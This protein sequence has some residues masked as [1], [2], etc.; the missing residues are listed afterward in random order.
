MQGLHEN[1]Q[2]SA[3]QTEITRSDDMNKLD[4]EFPRHLAR[5]IGL[6]IGLLPI[7]WLLV[8]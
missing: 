7:L 6:V 5:D 8:R 1:L 3:A 2:N 4:F